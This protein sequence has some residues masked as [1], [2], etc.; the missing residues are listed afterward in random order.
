M[1]ET[2][3]TESLI[4][5]FSIEKTLLTRPLCKKKPQRRIATIIYFSMQSTWKC[6]NIVKSAEKNTL[7]LTAIFILSKKMFF[8]LF[9]FVL[10]VDSECYSFPSG[11]RL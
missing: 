6:H 11:L 5:D 9:H 1:L 2:S 8:T 3:N 4:E 7:K 10:Y